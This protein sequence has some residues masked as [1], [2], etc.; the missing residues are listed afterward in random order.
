MSIST[1]IRNLP[2]AKVEVGGL[3]VS[4][5]L[6]LEESGVLVLVAKTTSV[7]N[8]NGFGVKTAHDKV[9]FIRNGL[10]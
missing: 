4:D 6:D 10:K 5:T 9:F 8:E 2:L 7:T 3:V 1:K